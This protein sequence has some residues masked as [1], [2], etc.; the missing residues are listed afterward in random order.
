M[1]SISNRNIKP[2]ISFI[3]PCY[4]EEEVIGY[5]IPKLIE[6]FKNGGYNLELVAVDNGSFDRTGDLLSEMSKNHHNIVCHRV[7]VNEGYGKGVLSGL[8]ICKAT[9][10]GIIPADGQVDAADVVSLYE[11]VAASNGRVMAKVRRRFRLD[12]LLRKIVSVSYNIFF[13]LLWPGIRSI[14]INGSPKI[15]PAWA[16]KSMRLKSKGWLLDPE[17]MIKSYM[18][19]LTILEFN[20]FG[21]MRGSGISHV[22]PVAAWAFF[23]RLLQFKFSRE[24]SEWRKEID[25]AE[26]E[27]EKQEL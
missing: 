10:I 24:L 26:P 5:T 11:A 3:M 2:D 19:G 4:N 13:R 16:V 6:A 12:G 18:L 7:E 22:S 14:D 17:I 8:P 15:I 20:V 23:T 25:G 27:A 9:W 1:D 21:R